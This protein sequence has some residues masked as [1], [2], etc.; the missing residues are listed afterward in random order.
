MGE[1]LALSELVTSSA[2]IFFFWCLPESQGEPPGGL[3]KALMATEI[4]FISLP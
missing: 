1:E 2:G 4:Y 3:F